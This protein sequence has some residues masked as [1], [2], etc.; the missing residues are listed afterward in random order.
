[1]TK[2]D[3]FENECCRREFVQFA[4]ANFADR[5]TKNSGGKFMGVFPEMWVSDEWNEFKSQHCPTA[6]NTNYWYT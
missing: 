3:T 5:Y 2:L 4:K 1:M 6:T